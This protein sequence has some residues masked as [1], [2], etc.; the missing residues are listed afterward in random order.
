MIV[1]GFQWPVEHDH[2]T[3]VILDGKL[4]FA[5]EEERFTRHK[6]SE[7]EPPLNSLKEAFKFLKKQGIKPKDV[8]AY[9]VNWDPSLFSVKDRRFRAYLGSV[10]GMFSYGAL[11]FEEGLTSYALDLVKGDY[12]KLAEQLI[13][14][15]IIDIGEEIPSEIKIY[16]VR[17]HLAHAASAY[18]FSGFNSATVLTIDGAGEYESTVIWKVKDGNFEPILSMYAS[19]ASLGFLYEKLMQGIKLGRLEGPGKGM[20]L[21]PYGK[22]SRYYD[23]LKEFVK[24]NPD[25]DEPYTIYSN[26]KV[27]KSKDLIKI[28]SVYYDIAEKVIRTKVLNWNPRGELNE[29]AVNI[30]WAVQKITEEAVL[31]TAKWA[32]SHTDEDRVALAG[33][34]ALNAKANM[35]LYYSR[36]FNEV[37]IFPAANDA[38]GPIGAAAYVYEH[39]LGGKM[40]HGR[41]KNVYLGPEYDEE[42][43]KKVV[44]DS[45]FRA[46]YVGDDVNAIADII[47][48]GGIVTW[49]QGRAELGPRALGNRSIVADPT[50]KDYWRL[51]NDIKGREWWRPLAPSLLDEDKDVYFKDPTSHE[52]MILMLRYKDEEVCKRVPVTCHVDLTARPQTVTRDQNRTWYD[53]IKTFKDIKGEGLIMNTSFNLA[54]EPLVETPQDALRSFAVKGFDAMYMQ[55]WIIYKR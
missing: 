10:I 30:A 41:L 44:Q 21:A 14:K 28:L 50:R 6:H 51:V 15:A 11:D 24:I 12:M 53:L 37:F 39:V 34:V 47:T 43:I 20:G 40:V 52:F 42:V 25:G 46:E 33:G 26:G 13:K 49:Y 38:G 29:D 18:Y 16:P 27:V 9:A 4:V 8:D 55:G 32:K 22:P 54:G 19:Y 1:I 23:K 5:A 45:K 36:M 7:G 3:A 17:H 48:K 2:A 35:E 31:A